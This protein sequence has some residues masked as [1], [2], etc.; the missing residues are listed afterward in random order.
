M[1]RTTAIIAATVI[2]TVVGLWLVMEWAWRGYLA[3][4]GW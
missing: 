3:A 1:N 2:V 4:R